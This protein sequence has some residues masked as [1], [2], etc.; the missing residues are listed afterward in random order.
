MQ[1]KGC[2]ATHV[3][4]AEDWILSTIKILQSPFSDSAFGSAL[5]EA[6]QFLWAGPE[7]DPV[8]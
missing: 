6:Q 1:V 2:R 4:L 3:Q 5:R 7:M 8:C